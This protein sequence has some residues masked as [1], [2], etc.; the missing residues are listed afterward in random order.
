MQSAFDA[1]REAVA[2]PTWSETGEIT[3]KAF[4]ESSFVAKSPH[5]NSPGAYALVFDRLHERDPADVGKEVDMAWH[6]E[7][8]MRNDLIDI[9]LIAQAIRTMKEEIC[10]FRDTALANDGEAKTGHALAS[11]VTVQIFSGRVNT[12][13]QVKRA[14]NEFID[15]NKSLVNKALG[16]IIDE[17]VALGEIKD[18]VV[19]LEL[20][21]CP[22]HSTTS[23]ERVPA[24]LVR[25]HE[26]A[27]W[28][29]KKYRNYH[30]I[31]DEKENRP[32]GREREQLDLSTSVFEELRPD[33]Q[34][35]HYTNEKHKHH[36]K[37]AKHRRQAQ[38]ANRKAQAKA[39]AKVEL[40]EKLRHG[41]DQ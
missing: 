21:W 16:A 13:Q 18:I 29:R 10:A 8:A 37:M 28:A 6:V 2:A 36:Q 40:V 12:L 24:Y 4:C 5:L 22:S 33:F 34:Q 32:G 17:S 23:P 27:E 11:K 31:G 20:R 25:A 1:A 3:L 30:R 15:R 7:P 41:H 14:Q 38:E 26:L 39:K 9:M 19:N 35:V